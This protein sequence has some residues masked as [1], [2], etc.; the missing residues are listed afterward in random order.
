MWNDL[1]KFETFK[2]VIS[3]V[4]EQENRNT[5][6]N[7]QN[8]LLTFIRF[9]LEHFQI[10]NLS[11]FQ[12]KYSFFSRQVFLNIQIHELFYKWFTKGHSNPSTIRNIVQNTVSFLSEMI[13]KTTTR[14]SQEIMKNIKDNYWKKR[15]TYWNLQATRDRES[16]RRLSVLKS[17]GKFL[18]EKEFKLISNSTKITLNQIEDKY[19]EK[20]EEEIELEHS[21]CVK[22]MESLLWKISFS[23]AIPRTSTLPLMALGTT[24]KYIDGK[25]VLV[26]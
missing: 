18:S 1:K 15:L 8:F 13:L 22:Y 17:N 4:E 16:N 14:Y 6:R 12:K 20:E 19:I 7:R 11:S 24:M 3:M 21:D 9:C 10:S 26:S 2:V 5:L 25:K 23:N